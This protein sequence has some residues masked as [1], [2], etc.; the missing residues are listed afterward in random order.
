ML[1]SRFRIL[2]DRNADTILNVNR[3]IIISCCVLHDI[4]IDN[5]D[6]W[7]NTIDENRESNNWQVIDS[8]D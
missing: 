5:E 1:K 4:C 8:I 2:L 6:E 7:E 3:G